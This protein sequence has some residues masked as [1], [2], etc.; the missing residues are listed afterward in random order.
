M[1]DSEHIHG[2]AIDDEK[3]TVNVPPST[4]E[5]HSKIEA[6]LCSLVGFRVA[7]WIGF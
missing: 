5:Q 7:M 4:I 3:D 2:L 1:P 6:E